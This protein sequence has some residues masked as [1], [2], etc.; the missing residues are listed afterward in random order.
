MGTDRAGRT[1]EESRSQGARPAGGPGRRCRRRPRAWPPHTPR[2]S[3]SPPP[4]LRVAGLRFL[5]WHP[6]NTPPEKGHEKVR[7]G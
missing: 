1:E 3:L 7:L 4:N 5:S 6:R 2:G